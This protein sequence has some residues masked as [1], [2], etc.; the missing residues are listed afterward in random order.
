MVTFKINS[1]AQ[2]MA[3]KITPEKGGENGEKTRVETRVKTRVKTGEKI[4]Q[5][6]KENSNVTIPDIFKFS[7]LTIKGV[8]WNIKELK[9]KGLLRRIG[10]TKGGH[11]EVP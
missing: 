5:V 3:A 9:K 10:P 7:G 2:E 4:L 11:W 1:R 8:E 6:I